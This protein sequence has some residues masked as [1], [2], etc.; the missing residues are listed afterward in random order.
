MKRRASGDGRSGGRMRISFEQYWIIK[1]RG[2]REEFGRSS[3]EEGSLR[4][5][6]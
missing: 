3:E 6:Q 2:V 1:Q 5:E 4:K